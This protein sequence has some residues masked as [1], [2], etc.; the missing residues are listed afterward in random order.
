MKAKEEAQIEI[1]KLKAVLHEADCIKAGEEWQR[2]VEMLK[3]EQEPLVQRGG[4]QVVIIEYGGVME[5]MCHNK[6]TNAVASYVLLKSDCIMPLFIC[7]RA[8]SMVSQWR[9]PGIDL[10]DQSSSGTHPEPPPPGPKSHTC[11]F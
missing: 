11:L 10:C 8:C 9:E 7:I 5:Y 3:A 4:S 6:S 1:V 2:E